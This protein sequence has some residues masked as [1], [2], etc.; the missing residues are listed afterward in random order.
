[1][2][3][4]EVRHI[5]V[6]RLATKQLLQSTKNLFVWA[7]ISIKTFDQKIIEGWIVQKEVRASTSH[8]WKGMP[9]YAVQ[10]FRLS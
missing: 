10:C 2:D 9:F 7:G 8:L 5:A 1:M 6:D 4:D 3:T